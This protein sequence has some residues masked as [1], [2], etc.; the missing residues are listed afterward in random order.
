MLSHSIASDAAVFFRPMSCKPK[1]WRRAQK[2]IAVN[3]IDYLEKKEQSKH[4]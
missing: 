2:I 3:V 4:Y 1:V